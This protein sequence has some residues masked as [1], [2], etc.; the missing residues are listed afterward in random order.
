M[1]NTMSAPN[2]AQA[3]FGVSGGC[4]W[5][6]RKWSKATLSNV[7]LAT[8]LNAARRLQW[9]KH[10]SWRL[11]LGGFYFFASLIKAGF[12]DLFGKERS[13][14][15]LFNYF[16][17]NSKKEGNLW[18]AR[19]LKKDKV[20]IIHHGFASKNLVDSGSAAHPARRHGIDAKSRIQ[21]Q[22]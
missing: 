1:A 19:T 22:G 17:Q 11:A 20:N 8:K 7:G 5:M 21:F 2:T 16:L 10:K 18:K 9:R 15:L 6:I 12:Q 13:S 4:F 14:V 3:K